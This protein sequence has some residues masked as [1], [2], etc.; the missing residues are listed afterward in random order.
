MLEHRFLP[1]CLSAL[2]QIADLKRTRCAHFCQYS[3][4]SKE[5]GARCLLSLFAH[6]FLNLILSFLTS[7][8][9]SYPFWVL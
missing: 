6:F 9:F 4:R 5:I 2:P 7:C 1:A 3:S 8:V